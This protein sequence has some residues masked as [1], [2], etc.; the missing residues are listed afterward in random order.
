MLLTTLTI[1]IAMILGKTY[2]YFLKLPFYLQ[3]WLKSRNETLKQTFIL[4]IAKK[5]F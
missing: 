1:L 3:Y 5:L 4:A 2:T